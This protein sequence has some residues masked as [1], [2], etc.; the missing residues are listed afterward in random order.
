VAQILAERD[1]LVSQLRGI[2]CVEE[3]FA[4]EQLRSGADHRLQRGI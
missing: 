4:G 1:Y 3:V 2:A